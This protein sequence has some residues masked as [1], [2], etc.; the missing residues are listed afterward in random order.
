MFE[1][2]LKGEDEEVVQ[3]IFQNLEHDLINQ[4]IGDIS[5]V[6]GGV[7]GH[8]SDGEGDLDAEGHHAHLD[9]EGTETG[10]KKAGANGTVEEA[11]EVQK[12]G[13]TES[14]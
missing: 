1:E 14:V 3:Q 2:A 7:F 9:A 11:I 6:G 13:S 8:G 5:Q 4:I 10:E 12:P